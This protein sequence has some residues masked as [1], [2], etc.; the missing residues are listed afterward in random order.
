MQAVLD[1]LFGLLRRWAWGKGGGRSGRLCRA[2]YY[3]LAVAAFAFFTMV[4][5]HK[6]G[7]IPPL[8]KILSTAGRAPPAAEGET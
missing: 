7:W 6:A 8:G 1:A 2:F 5:L 4:S 3:G